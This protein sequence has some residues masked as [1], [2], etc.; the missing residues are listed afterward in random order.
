MNQISLKNEM[1]RKAMHLLLVF[2]PIS[3]CLLGKWKSMTIFAAISTIVVSLDYMRRTNPA[4]KTIFL[5]IF[6]FVLRPH[7]IEENKFCG[8]S[9]VAFSTCINFLLFKPEIAVTAFLILVISD[10]FAA[11]IGRNFTS[12]AFFEKTLYGSAAF[13]ATGLIVLFA[14]GGFYGVKFWFYFFG[15]FS[16]CI[17]TLIEAR[18]SFFNVDDNFMIPISFSVIMTT[19][20][21]MWNY[22]Y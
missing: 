14:C 15:I 2:I 19:F 7:E 6:G 1:Y 22:A 8:A 21:I 12:Q 9:W 10:A 16:L 3:Y 17:V 20:D 4:V 11:I 13:F 18:P 5:K